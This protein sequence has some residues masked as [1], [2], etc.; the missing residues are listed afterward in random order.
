MIVHR[1]ARNG[2]CVTLVALAASFGGDTAAAT[3]SVLSH[4]QQAVVA[5]QT[6]KL[7]RDERAIVAGWSDARKLAEFFCSPAALAAFRKALPGADR[8]ALGP[9]DAGVANFVLAGNDTL[10]GR[11]TVRVPGAWKDYRF[12]CALDAAKGSVRSFTFEF[13]AH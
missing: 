5:Q 4:A 13:V 11:G 7:S 1:R 8:V 12:T 3:N 6:A 10:T 2:C 9:D